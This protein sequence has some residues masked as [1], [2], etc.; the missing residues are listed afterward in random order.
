MTAK[1]TSL[2]K[3]TGFALAVGVLWSFGGQATYA[4]CSSPTGAAGDMIYNTDFN[5]VQFCDNTS[6]IAMGA[7]STSIPDGDKGDITVSGS[8]AAWAVDTGAISAAKIAADSL[9]FTEFKDATALDASTD[10]AVDNAEVLSI[11]NTGTANSFVVNDAASDTTPFVIDAAGRFLIGTPT[12]VAHMHLHDPNSAIFVISQPGT[13]NTISAI[14]LLS[15]GDGTKAT[16][17]A[18]SKGWQILTRSDAYGAAQ[19]QNDLLYY[20]WN[21]TSWLHSMSLDSLTGFVGVGTDSPQ[22]MLHVAS[23]GYAQ[24]EKMSAGA[25]TSTDCDAANEAGRITFDTTNNLWYVCEGTSGWTGVGGAGVNFSGNNKLLGRATAGAGASEEIDVGTG[26][27]IVGGALV[28]NSVAPDVQTFN[29]SGTWNK[30]AT[31][32]MVFVECIGGGGGGGRGVYNDGTYLY[33]GGGGG[34]GGGYA[35]AWFAK[36]ELTSTVTVTIGAGGA[37]RTSSGGSGGSGGTT[38]FGTYLSAY[39]GGGGFGTAS[40]HTN[41]PAGGGGGS[42]GGTGTTP[43]ADGTIGYGAYDGGD[44]GYGR[45]AGPLYLTPAKSSVAGGGGGG[46]GGYINIHGLAGANSVY[47]GAGGGGGNCGYWNNCTSAT[48]FNPGAGGTS[49]K[50]GDGGAGGRNTTNG[51]NGSQ[52]GGGGGG[53]GNSNGGNGGAGRCTVK[54]Y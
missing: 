11:T 38:T 39:G 44:G 23:T 7:T 8:G 36:A 37:G 52:P 50:G 10:I 53:G 49:L 6:W 45:T 54:T 21:G 1:T 29:S 9:D 46:Q 13:G 43:A 30:P 15:M 17:H 22:S 42:I 20:Y 3:L 51:T 27:A 35:S 14:D 40:N 4:A 26:L 32:T 34:G 48:N 18:T 47:G 31:G 33:N 41:A 19:Q 12:G 24:F 28:P 16:G 5:V 2:R 25:P